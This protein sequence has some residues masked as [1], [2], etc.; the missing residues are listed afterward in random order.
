[1]SEILD[2]LSPDKLHSDIH[3][4]QL[5]GTHIIIDVNSSS[6]H[7]CDRETAEYLQALQ[8]AQGNKD[9]FREST[10]H[11]STETKIEIMSDLDELITAGTLFTKD[12][13][14]TEYQ[15]SESKLKSLCLHISHD[16]NLRCKYCFAGTGDFGGD[17]M[18]MSL[19][20]GKKAIDFLLEKSGTRK[21]LEID[22][23]GGEPLM[24][25]DV[26]KNLVEYG[27][28]CSAKVGKKIT[29][30]LTTNGVALSDDVIAWL[31]DKRIAT[32]LSLDGRKEINDSMRPF[33][34][35][36]GS[37]DVI[38]P[39]FKKLIQGRNDENYYL[40]GTFTKYNADFTT[41]VQAMLDEGFTKLSLEPV[42]AEKEAPYAFQDADIEK[43]KQEYEHLAL[44]FENE[45]A[46]RDLTFFH[47]NID[48][49][50]G[51][52]LPKRLS[53]CG[54]GHEYFAVTPEGKLYPCHQ[55]VGK[56]EYLMGTLDGD[57]TNHHA[58]QEFKSANVYAKE[59]CSSCWARFYC[60]G[61]C[62]ANA[63]NQNGDILKPYAL[64]CEL[65]K[66][67]IECAVYLEVKKIQK[68]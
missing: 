66:K 29:F 18:H 10:S 9:V 53:G 3:V 46:T 32:V 12:V 26:V 24:N 50:K 57:I 41:D 40:R 61:G 31:N 20:T 23:F 7:V 13:G 44:F 45:R 63:Y 48:I 8:R 27:D 52:C 38:V 14:K 65:Q 68:A 34:N 35:G 6:L 1:M 19:E 43:L 42:V 51:P 37:Y 62:H 49:Y 56:E 58:V 47:F 17:R 36:K 64:G 25:F 22:F 67:R 5:N 54:A 59:D 2:A 55:F 11:F 16:C 28:R 4:F 60:S 21:A 33:P 39:K 30:T 15:P